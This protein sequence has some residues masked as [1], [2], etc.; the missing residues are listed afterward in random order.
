V[1]ALVRDGKVCFTLVLSAVVND[2]VCRLH[3]DTHSNF[4]LTFLYFVVYLTLYK[5]PFG[6]RE[7]APAFCFWVGIPPVAPFGQPEPCPL[8]SID[9]EMQFL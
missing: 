8:E 6:V 9:Y 2:D 7:L 3:R 5:T 1:Q 4:S